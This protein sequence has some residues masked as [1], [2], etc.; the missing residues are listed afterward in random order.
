M[1]GEKNKVLNNTLKCVLVLGVIAIVCVA[2][3]AVA[4]KF[5]QVEIVL[6]RA[7]SDMINSIAPTGVENG[8][9]FDEG[10]IE[11]VDL[12]KGGYSVK[13]ID[14][15][16]GKGSNKKVRAVYASKTESGD[17]TL[18]VESEGKGNDAAI[19]L[20]IAY[21]SEN[22]ISGIAVKSQAESYWD[23]ISDI[24]KVYDVFVG[25][26]ASDTLGRDQVAAQSGATVK[27][28]L[29]GFTDAVNKANEFVLALGGT[30]K[31]AADYKASAE[32]EEEEK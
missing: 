2:L 19:V 20:L 28:T 6:D 3:L 1:S 5:M 26:S 27:N 29:G 22:K 15:F 18:V 13:S 12:G 21:D 8:V 23:R 32:A 14:D 11:M 9:A 24:N 7:T 25:T 16:N 30:Q 4:N 31:F 17:I 10:Y